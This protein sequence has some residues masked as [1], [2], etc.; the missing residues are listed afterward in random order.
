MTDTPAWIE[1]T[2]LSLFVREDFYAYFILLISAPDQYL[3]N[4]AWQGEDGAVGP[5]RAQHGAAL[6]DPLTAG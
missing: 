6:P 4:P 5:G 2:Q 3:Y 1:Q